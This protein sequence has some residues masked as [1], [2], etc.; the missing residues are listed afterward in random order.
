MFRRVSVLLG[1]V[2]GCSTPPPCLAQVQYPDALETMK[3]DLSNIRMAAAFLSKTE[4]KF[5]LVSPVDELSKQIRLEFDFEREA[6]VMD[7][8]A[9]HLKARP[10]GLSV[11]A[12]CSMSVYV[13]VW[14]TDR[15]TDRLTDSL[16][17]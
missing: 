11:S 12:A 1:Q 16:A 10:K 14:Q 3:L 2:T 5:D 13:S 8:I 4:I 9:S 17:D 7:S 6:R 15:Q